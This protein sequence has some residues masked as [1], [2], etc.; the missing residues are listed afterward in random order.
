M[1]SAHHYYLFLGIVIIAT[2]VAWLLSLL[3]ALLSLVDFENYS[4]FFVIVFFILPVLFDILAYAFLYRA[5]KGHNKTTLLKKV[6]MPNN[7]ILLRDCQS[8]VEVPCS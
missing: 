2:V 1:S 5:S 8:R 3:T 6:R 7:S 4:V